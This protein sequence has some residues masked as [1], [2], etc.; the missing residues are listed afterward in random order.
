MLKS[1]IEKALEAKME[2][3]LNK[4]VRSNGNKR[5]GK[6]KKIKSCFPSFDIDTPQ[7]YQSSFEPDLIKKRETILADNLSE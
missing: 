3:H 2:S 7:D 1:F 4:Q 5:N 6:G